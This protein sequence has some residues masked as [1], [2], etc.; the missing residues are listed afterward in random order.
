MVRCFFLFALC[1]GAQ[2]P[3]S[4]QP[5]PQVGAACDTPGKTT[6]GNELYL[7]K[8]GKWSYPV[9]G[10]LP[11][12]ADGSKPEWYPTLDGLNRQPEAAC[13]S[14]DIR[15]TS[16]FLP[17]S[18]IDASIPYGAMIYD[19][20]TPVDHA[21]I[22]VKSLQK[23]PETRLEADYVPVTAPADGTII[24]VGSLG[25][26]TSNR[27]V[28]NHGCGVYS[29]YM[30]I[31]RLTGVLASVASQVE[32]QSYLRLAQPVKAGEE[33]GRQRDNPLD[34]N[35][36]VADSWLPGF[37]NPLSYLYKE[38]WKPYTADP[39]RFFT[40]DL[41]A[42]YADVMQR[43]QEPRWGRIDYDRM[44][45][46]SGNWFLQGTLGYSGRL[47]AEY[48]EAASPL[49]GG[50]PL[51]GKNTY[52][53]GHLALAPHPVDPAK[54]IFSAG[55]WSNPDGDPRQAAL[56][57]GPDQKTP[58]QL[59]PDDG[60]VA[61]SLADAGP[62]DAAGKPVVLP[63]PEA[64][65]PVGYTLNLGRIWG[66]VALQLDPG[67]SLSVELFPNQPG[68]RINQLSDRKRTYQR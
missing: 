28:I 2:T 35:V 26:S 17:T 29:V 5:P 1:L 48:A 14:T 10:D 41:A 52:A 38:P 15:F 7:C 22:A 43:Q 31:N 63:N 59:T 40:P 25:R 62:V 49:P 45:G 11:L 16:P 60:V 54:W 56:S 4:P 37:A 30:V 12:P 27:V 57:I 13:P 42:A 3:D 67:G 39:T 20:V 64:P 51:P 66:T 6:F 61:Y 58:D 18:Q 24:E 47:I 68:L 21:Y 8:N 23:S 50:G 33:F 65:L 32:T 9:P 19:H 36:W 44:G 55:W 34:F 53:Y 46:A